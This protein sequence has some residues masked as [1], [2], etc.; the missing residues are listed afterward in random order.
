LAHALR[1]LPY[2]ESVHSVKPRP[3]QLT[4]EDLGIT[5][6]NEAEF[7]EWWG[8]MDPRWLVCADVLRESSGLVI[9]IS[10][11][12]RAIGRRDGLEKCSD[13]NVDQWGRVYG[14]DVMPRWKG[15]QEGYPKMGRQVLR[16]FEL[17]IDAGFSAIGYY[18]DWVNAKGKKSPGFHLGTRRNRRVRNPATWGRIKKPEGGYADMAAL[19]ALGLTEERLA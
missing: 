11:H 9:E 15:P 7:R 6:F 10:P 14:V 5:H 1:R 19:R 4:A 12:E 13:H 16:F 2:E 8:L 17:A 3:H 18:P